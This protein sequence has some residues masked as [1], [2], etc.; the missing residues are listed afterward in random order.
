MTQTDY[1]RIR[2][3]IR[4]D[5]VNDRLKGGSRLKVRELATRYNT[6]A[7]PVREALQQLQGEGIV[8]FIPNRGASVRTIDTD[9]VRDIYEIRAMVE[10]FLARWFV[11]HQKDGDLDR[12]EAI[13]HAFD[14][15][16]EA[17]D[18]PKLRDLNA[19]FHAICYNG[20]YNDEAVQLASRHTELIAALADRFPRFSARAQAVCREHWAIIGAIREQDEAKTAKLVETHVRRSGDHLI[21]RMKASLRHPE[22]AAV[23]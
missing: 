20:H 7:I 6:S 13:Q 15:A 16:V 4:G 21:E 23:R 19:E 18:W 8:R 9:F 12:L 10:P 11:R 5:I 22:A 2:D 3:L 17:K 14:A 1:N